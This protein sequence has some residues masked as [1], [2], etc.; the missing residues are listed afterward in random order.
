MNKRNMSELFDDVT[1]GIRNERVAD[2]TVKAAAERVQ[3]RLGHEQAAAQAGVATVEHLRGCDDFQALIPAYLGGFLTGARTM[4]LED[5][6]RECVPCRKALKDARHGFAAQPVSVK[7]ERQSPWAK[8]GLKSNWLQ[9]PAARWALAAAVVLG[10]GVF[11]WPFIS[12]LLPGGGLTAT[13]EASSGAVYR[14]G[15]NHTQAL[16]AGE[17]LSRGEHLRTSKDAGAVVKLSDG[18]TIEARERSEF[19]ISF[20]VSGITINLE[21]GNI[22]VQAA[23]Q[24]DKQLFVATADS[25]VSVKGTTFAV[26]SGTKGSR[27]SV[28]EGEVQVDRGGQKTALHPGEQLAT[29]PSIAAVSVKDE[30]AWSRDAQRYKQIL[31]TVKRDIDAK[32]AMPGNRYST[33]LLDLMPENTV[34]YAAIP[35]LSQTLAQAKSILEQNIQTNPELRAWYE[36]QAAGE[37]KGKQGFGDVVA[38][39]T[40]FGQFL[41]QEIAVGASNEGVLA[42]AEVSNPDSFRAYV[43]QQLAGVQGGKEHVL[44]VEN[45]LTFNA[46]NHAAGKA[47]TKTGKGS[48]QLLVWLN[49]NLLA[50][51]TD[52]TK[53]QTLAATANGDGKNVTASRF[54]ATPFHA[55]LA[56]VYRE[57][58]G[59]VIGADLEKLIV[60]SIAT[61]KNQ[62]KHAAILNQLGINRAQHFIAE[63][64]EVNGQPQNRAVVTFDQA[65]GAQRGL[66][67]WL[68]QPGSMGALQFISPDANVVASFVVENPTA[69]Y[70]D[71]LNTLKTADESA[72][73]QFSDLQLQHNVSLRD[74]FAAK[75]GGEFAVA[76]DGPLL[77]TPSWK[78]VFEVNNPEGLQQSI[79]H[80]VT[81]L[82]AELAAKGQTQQLTWD[83]SQNGDRVFYR[84]KPATGMGEVNYTFAYGYLIAAPSKALVENAI[85]YRESGYTLTQSAKFKAALPADK[86]ANFSAMV[87]Y[88]VGSILAPLAKRAGTVNGV[89][90][91]GQ[92][93]LQKLA[94][95][96]AGLAYVYSLGDRMVL[97]LNTEDGP[98]GLTPSSL[99]GM[100]G[101]FGLGE[102]LKHAG[103]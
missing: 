51:S 58:A 65:N 92:N 32:V 31:D 82:N 27:V 71:L 96:K 84:L 81:E 29:H 67:S 15:E 57:G 24:G 69:L 3:T 9:M 36:Q 22:I 5:H 97:S 10:F 53:L 12:Q 16:K 18:S 50:A 89:S 62:E 98:V 66:A 59:L 79:E 90:K 54:N 11:A 48:D 38:K 13:V 35:N 28:V 25:L 2:A 95:D 63:L 60:H 41:G 78:V 43:E 20:T 77:P 61:E 99:L 44:F 70:D 39:L 4:L 14:V 17:Q 49:G 52:V 87:Y 46:A 30:V 21:R 19:S 7:A 40:E 102:I 42:L 6:T 83:N 68:A 103:H 47:A 23:K 72:W 64:K 56:D 37:K 33:R 88:N 76:V 75:L 74:D 80:A 100:G 86:Q 8:V 73:Q 45:P 101:G 94:T 26:N 34:F 93:V 1:A 91:D 85:K 55:R